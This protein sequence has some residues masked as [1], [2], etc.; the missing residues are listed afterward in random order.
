MRFLR[1]LSLL[2]CALVGCRDAA[3]S[4]ST[5]GLEV[6]PERVN[7]GQVWL[8]HP[9]AQTIELVNTGRETLEVTLVLG[10]PFETQPTAR[11]GGGDTVAIPVTVTSPRA[12][13][14]LGTLSVSWKD[15]TREVALEAQA[16]LPPSCPAQDCREFTFDP[17]RGGCVERVLDDGVACGA[18]NLCISGGMCVRGE[19]VGQA[20]DCNDGNACTS[21]ACDTS[22]GCIHDTVAC[23]EPSDPCQVAVCDATNGCG[24]APA[25]D[26]AAC[27]SNDCSTAHVCI[28]GQCVTRPAPDGSQCAAPTQCR[29]A[30]LCRHQQCELPPPALLQPRWRYTPPADHTVAF[31]GHVDAAG[32]LYATESWVGVP[33]TVNAQNGAGEDRNG[34]AIPPADVPITAIVSLTPNG[35]LRYR[36]EVTQGCAGCTYGHFFAID[37]AGQ[38]LFFSSMGATQ[39]RS[40]VDG[41]LLWR[42]TP[43]QGVPT[44]DVRTDGGA[45]FSINPPLLIGADVVGIPLIEGVSDHHSYVQVL[46]RATGQLRW[47]FHRKGHL[48]G[49][50]VSTSGELWTSS[51]NCWAVAGEM[52]RVNPAGVGQATKFLAWMPNI[53]GDGFALGTANGRLQS[54]DS[55]LEL[56]DLTPS[57]GASAG[58]TPLVSDTQLVLW[59]RGQLSAH[60]LDGGARTFAYSRV[61][62]W[63]PQFELTA[64]G[65]ATWTSQ[66][67]DG[68]FLGAVNASG[69][70]LFQCPLAARVD[71]TTTVV[72]GRAYVQ[73]DNTL[74]AFDAPGLDVA[75]RGW[76]SRF[77]S[78][79]RGGPA[80]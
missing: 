11:V 10:A 28:A 29:G 8:G 32:N 69:D 71:S 65:G 26:G 1:I 23:A 33:N 36:V 5:S 49:T 67:P 40:L 25:I 16:V 66:A 73:A 47:Q 51:A 9:A 44:Y 2:T 60:P 55:T 17:A 41:H 22:T 18:T 34:F 15:Q 72:R 24:F 54:L 20:R 53:Y 37:S 78:L 30:G 61:L 3:L 52:A 31:L 56:H 80:R 14:V 77:G 35:L 45:S 13:L 63:G 50:G 39:A 42:V 19:C 57:T 75:P 43:T 58:A 7:F 12:G 79:G 74:V 64:Q 70:E 27:G 48:Y 76:V 68:G 6:R 46:D 21:D 62:G 4:S 59:D 38:R